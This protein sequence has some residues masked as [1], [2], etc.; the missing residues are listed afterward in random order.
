MQR[1]PRVLQEWQDRPDY[2]SLT[3]SLE[4]Q[5]AWALLLA[6]T[7]A[8][9]V[10]A[11]LLGPH[12]PM[13]FGAAAAASAATAATAAAAAAAAA[14]ALRSR[15]NG[16]STS[17]EIVAANLRAER[18]AATA[19]AAAAAVGMPRQGSLCGMARRCVGFAAA[20]E[21]EAAALATACSARQLPLLL[22]PAA[23]D[24]AASYLLEAAATGQRPLA[25][26]PLECFICNCCHSM[27]CC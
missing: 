11:D 20:G 17:E 1:L 24:T 14:K 5:E 6:R 10:F 25:Y 8:P 27:C 18:A 26:A 13:P 4:G 23:T 16:T 21:Q 9:R 2:P 3:A 12:C 15:Q 22:L 7:G 19:A